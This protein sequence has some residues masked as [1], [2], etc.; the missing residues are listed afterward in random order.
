MLTYHQKY[1]LAA[2][3]ESLFFDAIEDLPLDVKIKACQA[4]KSL[5]YYLTEIETFKTHQIQD[6]VQQAGEVLSHPAP[7]NPYE[8]AAKPQL[9][10]ALPPSSVITKFDPNPA[11]NATLISWARKGLFNLAIHNDESTPA[12]AEDVYVFVEKLIDKKLKTW[13]NDENILAIKANENISVKKITEFNPDTFLSYTIESQ[14]EYLGITSESFKSC[15]ENNLKAYQLFLHQ[16]KIDQGKCDTIEKINTE[17]NLWH[18]RCISE[19]KETESY[20]GESNNATLSFID[21]VE[22]K[23]SRFDH[24]AASAKANFYTYRALKRIALINE[25]FQMHL[26]LEPDYLDIAYLLIKFKQTDQ[27]E[28]ILKKCGKD[29]YMLHA[30]WLLNLYI[31]SGSVS[32][33]ILDKFIETVQ[34]HPKYIDSTLKEIV[35]KFPNT[36]ETADYWY[37]VKKALLQSL[38]YFDLLPKEMAKEM[39]IEAVKRDD[40]EYQMLVLAQSPESFSAKALLNK[41]SVIKLVEQEFDNVAKKVISKI[42]PS[43]LSIEDV[44]LIE[45]LS[46]DRIKINTIKTNATLVWGEAIQP[47]P[48]PILFM[49]R[50]P[51]ATPFH[52]QE[53]PAPQTQSASRVV[54]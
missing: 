11:P 26:S 21:I 40:F 54:P 16:F 15:D 24:Y 49:A 27:L 42:F 41:E 6:I 50:M 9:A 43:K 44:L 52:T 13:I 1:L 36:H 7:Q 20:I 32:K 18:Q 22:A 30:Q 33:K 10:I 51:I 12:L 46:Q 48:S 8:H 23:L 17:L 29:F 39:F 31:N 5:P 28:E 38:E 35:T 25:D 34:I 19:R 14:L 4:V 3:F 53:A 47:T 45:K 37:L 2:S